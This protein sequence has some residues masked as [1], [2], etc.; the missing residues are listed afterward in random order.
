M[1]GKES[2]N[3]A[4]QA[5]T[6]PEIAVPVETLDGQR[7]VYTVRGKPFEVPHR[8][9]VDRVL[10]Y[11]SYG[12]VCSATDA[13][14][15]DKVAIKK[16]GNLF[17]DLV[18]GKRVLRELKVLRHLS[19]P[20]ILKL[21]TV[22][23]ATTTRFNDIYVVTNVMDADLETIINSKQP[24]VDGHVKFFMAQLLRA[25]KYIHSAGVM[26]RDLKPANLLVNKNCELTVCDFGLAR[27][28]EAAEL[29]NY[30]V[31][32]WYRAPELLLLDTTYATA[33]DM[34][35]VGLILAELLLRR[36]LLA[37]RNYLH[38]LHLAIEFL[39]SPDP[40]A[41]RH[42][43]EDAQR[44][45]D[46]MG[47]VPKPNI[48]DAFPGAPALAVDLVSKLVVFDPQQ[49]LTA[50]EALAH[51]YLAKHHRESA[52][53]IADEQF[54]WNDDDADYT[55]T[56]L[57]ADFADEI[58]LHAGDH[59]SRSPTKLTLPRITSVSKRESFPEISSPND[60]RPIRFFF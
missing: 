37:G 57:R 24:L 58:Q 15:G 3:P 38:Q 6:I 10:G 43:N 22:L 48:A 7:K 59:P 28:T 42:M 50:D 9:S 29:T 2:R 52:E 55:E 26:H 20:N 49:R 60:N 4:S 1:G 14:T 18:D 44:Y 25:V 23:P 46:S 19:H 32:R 56:S 35:S 33:I 36:P 47:K 11:G 8:Y 17:F 16:T 39:G 30:V 21:H 54:A 27:G 31:T 40:S 13:R 53:P 41:L 45:V 34:W 5:N 51:P 12:I